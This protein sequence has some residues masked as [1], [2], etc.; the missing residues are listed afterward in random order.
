[1]DIDGVSQ[2][3][4]VWYIDLIPLSARKNGLPLDIT[5]HN[6]ATDADSEDPSLI[7][8]AQYR[9]NIA[10]HYYDINNQ[11]HSMPL[12][13][14]GMPCDIWFND[15]HRVSYGGCKMNQKTPGISPLTE[16]SSPLE[17]IVTNV[18]RHWV[19]QLSPTRLKLFIDSVLIGD[20]AL[21]SDFHNITKYQ[22]HSTLFTYNTG[23]QYDT[24]VP[25]SS[26]LHWDNL[27]F[28][29]SD[30]NAQSTVTHNY[31]DG[32]SSGT[33][34]LISR[35]M[36]GHEIPSGNRTTIVPIPDQIGSPIKARLMFTLQAFGYQTYSWNSGQYVKVNGKNYPFPNPNEN[37]QKPVPS[38]SETYIPHATG[39]F[40]DPNDLISG[41]NTIQFGL[42]TDILNVH[43]ELDYPRA[44]APNYTQPQQVFNQVNFTS[45]VKPMMNMADMYWFIEQNMGLENIVVVPTS[46][47]TYIPTPTST[48]APGSPS[49]TPTSQPHQPGD[50]NN[51]GKVNLTDYARIIQNFNKTVGNN[52]DLRLI[53]L[54]G[55][56]TIDIY[57]Y[58]IVIQNFG[59]SG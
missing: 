59:L 48:I 47:P 12:L 5:S 40:I 16:A 19:V 57:D 44:Q 1:M 3:R 22:V 6:D 4:D 15:D 33:Y 41:N 11:P 58:S 28:T 38:I 21:P 39:I 31:I 23:K 34:P 18:R 25:T 20:A 27:G 53:D 13:H 14:S 52:P 10:F 43:I 36:P 56:G 46:N 55:N 2:P 24:V 37:L 50:T 26:M 17:P 35:G 54:S 8:I 29:S 30:P 49:V 32:G 51:D 45:I 42:N 9:D 7:R